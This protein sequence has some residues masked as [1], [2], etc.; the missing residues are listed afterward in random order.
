ML[1]FA[2]QVQCRRPHNLSFLLEEESQQLTTVNK[3]PFNNE[4]VCEHYSR[5]LTSPPHTLKNEMAPYAKKI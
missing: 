4:T 3:R 1:A 5:P 2:L